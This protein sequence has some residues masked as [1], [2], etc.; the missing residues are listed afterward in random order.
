MGA[1]WCFVVNRVVV[2]LLVVGYFPTGTIQAAV[3][4]GRQEQCITSSNKAGYCMSAK[5]C[6]SSTFVDLRSGDDK[7]CSDASL[8]CCPI[9]EAETPS[10]K[11]RSPLYTQCDSNRGYCVL[12]EMCS[13]RTFRLRSNRCPSFAEVC[14]PKTAVVD[15]FLEPVE[16]VVTTT[17][18]STT[19]SSTASSGTAASSTTESYGSDSIASSTAES[20]GS[21]TIANSTTESSGATSTASGIITST[22]PALDLPPPTTTSTTTTSTYE[23]KGTSET[24][25]LGS[26]ESF[27]GSEGTSS[28]ASPAT[29]TLDF[30]H[31]LMPEFTP[32]NF[33][34][35]DCGQRNRNGV[36]KNTIS[37][38]FLAEYGELPWMVALLQ[39]PEKRYCCNGAL[40]ESNAV[41]TTVHCVSKCGDSAA[42]LLVRV[43]EWDM[44][45]ADEMMLPRKDIG[46]KNVHK[47]PDYQASSLINNIAVLQLNVPLEYQ[48]TVQPVC[49][50]SAEYSLMN[51]E[52][53]IATG[54]GAF[55]KGNT[56]SAG[57][58]ILKRLDLQRVESSICKEKLKAEQKPFEFNMDQ[59]FVCANTN[60]G[61][62]ERP[63]GGDAGSPVVVEIPGTVDRYYLH[64]LVS[65]GYSCSQ[66]RNTYTVLTQVVHFRKWIDETLN[67]L[68]KKNKKSKNKSADARRV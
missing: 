67:K 5:S 43:G 61:D 30:I 49:L 2:V 40:I 26:L 20:Y 38:E 27:I 51:H 68:K 36:A 53:M 16:A 18:P 62:R 8:H 29:E 59:S 10:G 66:R 23:E 65:W 60:H 31:K 24:D 52:T 41:L 35:H 17:A 47:H 57:S 15:D 34:Y 32:E 22:I 33:T 4:G 7:S 3:N 46:V 28:I 56:E 6:N 63:C 45:S 13:V 25:D 44:S 12:S 9:A 48:A 54:W 58:K 42:H 14:C 1:R 11:S 55:V 50:P 19:T 39:L 21:D 64:G 37:Q